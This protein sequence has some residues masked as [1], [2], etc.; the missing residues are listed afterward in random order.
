VS[1]GPSS[2]QIQ[3]TPEVADGGAD[4]W[5]HTMPLAARALMLQRSV[6]NRS[7]TAWIARLQRAPVLRSGGR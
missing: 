3:R 1:Q 4:K 2:E 6:G 5:L 7:T